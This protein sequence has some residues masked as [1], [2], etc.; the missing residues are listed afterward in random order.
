MQPSWPVSY[1]CQTS[2]RNACDGEQIANRSETF[3]TECKQVSSERFPVSGL[4]LEGV[5]PFCLLWQNNPVAVFLLIAAVAENL[6]DETDKPK[7]RAGR[8]ALTPWYGHT[9]EDKFGAFK[10]TTRHCISRRSISTQLSVPVFM[11]KLQ[12]QLPLSSSS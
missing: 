12:R 6:L 8:C 9:C 5:E 2:P 10:E 11:L 1:P 3:C 4:G 7:H